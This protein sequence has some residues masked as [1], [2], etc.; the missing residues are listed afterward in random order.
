MKKALRLSDPQSMPQVS[1]FW[2]VLGCAIS[3]NRFRK[4]AGKKMV[5]NGVPFSSSAELTK[6]LICVVGG[7]MG[8]AGSCSF[9]L[10]FS[11][12]YRSDTYEKL[13]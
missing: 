9:G 6:S 13:G 8:D 1:R 10:L 3:R 2:L 12:N 5:R 7:G 11:S 4:S